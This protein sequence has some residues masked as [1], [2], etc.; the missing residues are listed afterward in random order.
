MD[1]LRNPGQTMCVLNMSLYLGLVP[2]GGRP[3]SKTIDSGRSLR[4][5]RL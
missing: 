2:A 1:F 4:N 3:T 5:I